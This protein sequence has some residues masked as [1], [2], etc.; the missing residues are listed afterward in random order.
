ME[1]NLLAIAYHN[2]THPTIFY[3][4]GIFSADFPGEVRKSFRGHFKE[5]LPVLYLNGAQGDIRIENSLDPLKESDEDKL[6]R[7]SKMLFDK[8][9]EMYETDILYD[10]SPVLRHTYSDLKVGVRLPSAETLM[11]SRGILDRIDSGEEIRGLKMIMAFGSVH[12]QETFG[13]HPFDILPVHAARIGELAIVTESCELFCQFGLDIKRRSPVP[14][15][16][17]IGLTDGLN[18]YCPTVYGLMGGGY[19]GAPISWT[20]LEPYAGYKIVETAARL[21]NEL[22]KNE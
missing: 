19:S 12:L 14:N 17:V 10:E 7:I 18:G 6:R 4:D 2:T 13:N 9:M 11:E 5:D 22:W 16:I 20:R 1:D 15:T 8:T 3:A 21:L